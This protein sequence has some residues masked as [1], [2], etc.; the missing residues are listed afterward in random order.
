MARGSSGYGATADGKIVIGTSVDTSGINEGLSNIEKNFKRLGAITAGALSIKGLVLFGKAALD[1]SS[2]I[3]EVQNIVDSAFGNMKYKLEDLSQVAVRDFGLSQLAVKQ[4]G[5]SFMAMGKAMGISADKASD[6]AV[7]LTALSGDMASFFNISQEYARVALSAVYTGE[8]ETL[9]RYGIVLTEAN[10]Q[11]YALQQGIEKSVHN[12]SAQEKAMLRYDYIMQ[13]AGKNGMNLIGDFMRTSNT[14]ANQVRVLKEHWTQFLITIGSM[15]KVVFLPVV[16]FLNNILAAVTDFANKIGKVLAKLFGFKW[17]DLA[18]NV[19]SATTSIVDNSGAIDDASDSED[20]LAKST[21]KATKALKKQLQGFD[22]LNNISTPSSTGAGGAGTGAGGIG[23]GGGNVVAPYK[24]TGGFKGIDEQFLKN[25]DSLYDMGRYISDALAK[26]MESIDWKSIYD[27][28]KNFGTGLADF[29]NGLISPRLFGDVGKTIAS[30]LNTAIY[31]ALA[32]GTTFDWQNLGASLA[33]SVNQFFITF[34]FKALAQGIN[35]FVQGIYNMIIEFF[36]D[37]DWSAV[38]KGL[39]DFITNL[40]SKTINIII[41]AIVLDKVIKFMVAN[42]VIKLMHNTLAEIIGNTFVEAFTTALEGRA[43]VQIMKRF[44][45]WL[46][47]ML[48]GGTLLTTAVAGIK[49]LFANIGQAI[50]G[51]TIVTTGG[52]SFGEQLVA[53]FSGAAE[54]LSAILAP[55][56]SIASIIGGVVLSVVNFFKMWEDGWN[57]VSEILKD[58]GIALAA[59]GAVIAGVAAAPAAIVAAIVAAVTTIIIL[60][61]D[62]WDAVCDFFS[63]IPDWI[64]ENVIQPVESFFASAA[65]IV[66]GVWASIAGFFQGVWDGIVTIFSPVADFFYTIFYNAWVVVEDIWKLAVFFFTSVWNGIVD[67]LTPVVQAIEDFFQSVWDTIVGIFNQTVGFFRNVFTGAVNVIKAAWSGVVSFF[68]GIW[69]GIRNAF[70]SV[71]N[72]FS[73]VFT[74]AWQAI[75]KPFRAVGAFFGGIWT[76]IRNTFVNI[77][78]RVGEAIGG[79]FKTAIN[80]VLRTAENVLNAPITAVNSLMDKINTVPGINLKK[81][82]TFN[83]PR[84][85]KGAVI[86]PNKEFMAILGDQKQG[87]NIETPL[88]T[89]IQAFNTALDKRGNTN[90]TGDIVV[91]IDGREVFRAVRQQDDDYKNRTGESAFA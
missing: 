51:E 62:N 91:Q 12:M 2:D 76:T 25:I 20:D 66:E 65:E 59:V 44:A 80:A 35:A 8:T 6:M 34:D 83:L 67:A 88:D 38:L 16:K 39:W 52:A 29:L 10:L 11:Q 42:S 26:S 27:K 77:G 3:V 19:D 23:G 14:W 85:A 5:G 50:A 40:D 30:S 78:T 28:A 24:V 75:Q 41:G 17:E 81:L 63:G 33:A 54:S 43:G 31:A 48:G 89:M 69:N 74:K 86:P 61:H 37:V 15:L 55:L 57:V 87:T 46:G 58:L 1:A 56:A 73:N 47:E 18:A 71:V 13:A 79:A 7:Q 72:F 82:R 4:T 21:D 60:L 90:D 84:L 64:Y 68:R 9:K 49:T 70:N 32:F 22:E 45:A 36:K 53:F